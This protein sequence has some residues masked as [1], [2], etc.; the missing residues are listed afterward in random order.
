VLHGWRC[1]NDVNTVTLKTTWQKIKGVS[2]SEPN[3][4]KVEPNEGELAN[5]VSKIPSS[6]PCGVKDVNDWLNCDCDNAGY[7]IKTD[8]ETVN[9]LRSGERLQMTTKMTIAKRKNV[10]SK[11]NALQVLD[12]AT[13]WMEWQ[14]E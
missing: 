8:D 4:E 11:S 2:E 3:T 10:P 5:T 12:L 7:H 1:C 14:E 13:A 6:L 9:N